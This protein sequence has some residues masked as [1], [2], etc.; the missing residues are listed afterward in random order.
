MNDLEIGSSD[1][2]DHLA[3][4]DMLGSCSA[5]NPPVTNKSSRVEENVP[6]EL[7]IVSMPN[8][9]MNYFTVS[10][11]GGSTFE[12]LKLIVT[13]L[14]GRIIEQKD[15]LQT[16]SSFKIGSNY[17]SGVY[18]VEII[19]GAAHKQIKLVKAGNQH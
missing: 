1:V 19:Q 10:I 5:I 15:N 4:G 17:Y 14:S 11:K 13:D 18:I 7:A 3:H 16:N 12:K 6:T 9:S 2:P 8:P